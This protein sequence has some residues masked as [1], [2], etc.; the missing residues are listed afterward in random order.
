MT[1]HK[2]EVTKMLFVIAVLLAG[3]AS[4]E[5]WKSQL[6][7]RLPEFGHRNWIVIA[8]SAYP[9]QSAPGIET[10]YTGAGQIE[11]ATFRSDLAYVDG[12]R[13][14]GVV[15]TSAEHDA[16]RRD[17]TING[18]F[19]DPTSGAVLDYVGGRQDL[20]RR[21]VRAIGQPSARNARS[22]R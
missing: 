21:V 8:D 1:L 9:R 10:V 3:Q 2:C 13:P 6:S 17:F 22:R 7:E 19:Y 12:R 5:E 15:F 11:V 14:Q 4:A 16:M 20:D 18:L